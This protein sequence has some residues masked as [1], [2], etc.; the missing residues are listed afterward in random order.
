MSGSVAVKAQA[1]T[2]LP[3]RFGRF[4]VK[5][6]S[7][8]N[9]L[10]SLAIIA[11]T[12]DTSTEIPVRVHSACF[13]SE[14][15]GSLK[16]DCKYQL[17]FALEYISNHGGVVLYL[18]QEGRGVGLSNKIR[19]Y[20]LQEQGYDTVDAN[21]ALG[22]P[23]D[24]RSYHQAAFALCDLGIHRIKL[25][26]NNPWKIRALQALG[27]DVVDRIPIPPVITVHSLHYLETKRVRMGHLLE[28]FILTDRNGGLQCRAS[29]PKPPGSVRERPFVHANL[30]LDCLGR[31]VSGNGQTVPLSCPQDWRRV[32]QLRERYS[33]VVVGART[34]IVDQPRLTARE[35]HL[36]RQPR[37]QPDRVI[38]AGSTT[39]VVV[40]DQRRSFVVGSVAPPDGVIHVA[41]AG[42]ELRAPLA[43]LYRLN[44]PTLLVEGGLTLLRSFLREKFVE[45]LTVYV[46]T[47]CLDAAK[48][49]LHL[50]LPE[51]DMKAVQIERFGNGVL[52]TYGE[53]PDPEL[54]P[55]HGHRR[56][57]LDL[58]NGYESG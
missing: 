50:G 49:A 47:D 40:Q 31:S 37:R 48:R 2:M 23:D 35:E 57:G 45:L 52:I 20:A 17:D 43:D 15:L 30:A 12:L 29:Q 21:R 38:F 8:D 27:I 42:H 1:E 46:R 4:R 56:P 32:H 58:T 53:Y 25:I 55:V 34:W 24:A 39:C 33:A 6:Y 36:G 26:T 16:C 14:A 28:P 5:I 18:P 10:E 7:D 22:L 44:V 11:G 41:A 9:G 13:T 3:T 54:H 51:L 19:A